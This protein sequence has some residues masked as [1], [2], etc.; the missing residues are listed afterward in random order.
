MHNQ[1]VQMI[2]VQVAQPH[3]SKNRQDVS[4]KHEL[5]P[6]LSCVLQIDPNIT[7]HP[8]GKELFNSD[9]TLNESWATGILS[10]KLG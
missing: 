7:I 6:D 2:Y 8:K 10:L 3:T 4:L 5:I 9:I 1:R